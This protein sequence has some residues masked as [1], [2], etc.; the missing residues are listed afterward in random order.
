[1]NRGYASLTALSIAAALVVSCATEPVAVARMRKQCDANDVHACFRL[2]KTL[3]G[4]SLMA[5]DMVA[6]T[7]LR[8]HAFALGLSQ[9]NKKQ[10]TASCYIVGARYYAGTP[11]GMKANRQLARKYFNQAC[12]AGS[13]RGCGM[14]SRMQR[15]DAGQP[16]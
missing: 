11:D 13:E 8:K 9:C 15:E 1:M 2:S 7:K 6:A 14:A 16:F 12:L 3:A 5:V 4:G 10:I